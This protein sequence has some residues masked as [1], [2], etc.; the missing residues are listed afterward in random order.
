MESGPIIYGID[1]L[2]VTCCHVCVEDVIPSCHDH[3]GGGGVSSAN[4]LKE[5]CV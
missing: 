3:L 4:D 2:T 1:F 5:K